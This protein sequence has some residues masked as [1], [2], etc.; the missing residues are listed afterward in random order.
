MPPEAYKKKEGEQMN[1]Y[2][3]EP[4]ANILNFLMNVEG[5]K[6]NLKRKNQLPRIDNS[7]NSSIT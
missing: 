4:Q 2:M 3:T 1:N 7:Q 6:K 5:V